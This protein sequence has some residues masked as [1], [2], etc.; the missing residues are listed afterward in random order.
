MTQFLGT[1]TNR[2]D[3][4][5]RVS[6]PAQFRAVLKPD[7]AGAVQMVLRPSLKH[8]CIEGWPPAA[9]QALAKPLETLDIFS[10][11]HDDLAT[12]LYADAWPMESDKEGRIVLPD[13]LK[14]HAGLTDSVEFLGRGNIFL[15]WEPGGA[16]HRRTEARE[17]ARNLTLR[18]V[19][20]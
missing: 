7:G 1:H 15:I 3:A 10:E 4:K 16:K 5:G 2:L 20:A 12:A 9:F 11:D 8:R 13:D 19:A 17:R 14:S 6:I 18:G